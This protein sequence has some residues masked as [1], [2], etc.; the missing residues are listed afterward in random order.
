MVIKTIYIKLFLNGDFFLPRNLELLKRFYLKIF[1]NDFLRNE[2]PK[3]YVSQVELICFLIIL[4]TFIL[5][6]GFWG[7]S[8]NTI[9]YPKTPKPQICNE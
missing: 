1:N 4:L 2:K 8:I 5:K 9:Q 3:V 6:M 7:L